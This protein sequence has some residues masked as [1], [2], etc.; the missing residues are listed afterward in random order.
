[1]KKLTFLFIS[2]ALF[3][4]LSAQN[5]FSELGIKESDYLTLSDGRY[6]EFH[7]YNDFERVGSAIIDMHTNKIAC[8]IDRDSVIGEGMAELDMTTRFLSVDPMAEKYYQLS[9]YA[10]CANNPIKNIDPNGMEIYATTEAIM[11]IFYALKDGQNVRMDIDKNGFIAPESLKDQAE[12]SDDD[13]L[14]DLYEIAS[15]PQIVDMSVSDCY[16]YKDNDGYI[17]NSDNDSE[18]KF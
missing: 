7:G 14:Q 17:Q 9:P 1:M 18:M 2:F 15:A 11:A 8:F 12:S 10:Y 16:D 4:K 3:G 6:D 13:V 5:P